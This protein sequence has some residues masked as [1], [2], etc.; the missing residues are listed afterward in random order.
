MYKITIQDVPYLKVIGF[1]ALNIFSKPSVFIERKWVIP[2]DF[3]NLVCH[4]NT[5]SQSLDKI[6][7]TIQMKTIT[8]KITTQ[9]SQSIGS[10]KDQI[11]PFNSDNV[12]I[13]SR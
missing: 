3:P 4:S 1:I 13:S 6:A 9:Y 12:H 5:R 7:T 10:V 2:G 8:N 11:C